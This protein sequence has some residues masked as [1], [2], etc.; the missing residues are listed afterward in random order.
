MSADMLTLAITAVAVVNLMTFLAFWHDK[1]RAIRGGRRVRESDL[2]TLALIGGSPGALVAR[3]VFRHKTR[4]E[5]FA[6]LL[7]L[8]VAVQMGG[9]AGFFLL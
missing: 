6:T 9:V 1:R 2:L 7:M 5:P 4:K 3:R 8:I